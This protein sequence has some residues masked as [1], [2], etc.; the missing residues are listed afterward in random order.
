MVKKYIDFDG[1]IKDTYYP[2]FEDYLIK[3]ENGE[4]VNDLEHVIN[5]DWLYVLKKGVADED[6]NAWSSWCRKRYSG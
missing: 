5:K 1:V 4:E 3:K 6:Y 2:L